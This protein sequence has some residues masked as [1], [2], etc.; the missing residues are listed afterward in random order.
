MQADK[1]GSLIALAFAGSAVGPEIE[2]F[3]VGIVCTISSAFRRLKSC[4]RPGR[5]AQ[6]ESVPFTRVR[7][8]YAWSKLA[9]KLW[10]H[11]REP[12]D[13]ATL[14]WVTVRTE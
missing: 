7:P 2:I 9:L 8:H 14:G 11:T 13:R 4:P 12:I 10:K 6:R 5:L 3:P 1:C